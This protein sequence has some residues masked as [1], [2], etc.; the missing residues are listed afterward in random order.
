MC[1]C[2]VDFIVVVRHRVDASNEGV[3]LRF[4]KHIRTSP[5]GLHMKIPWPVERVYE[6]SVQRIKTLEFGFETEHAGRVT[7]YIP[8]G[9]EHLDVAE[10]LTGDLN[11]AHVE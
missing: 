5:P 1:V 2:A 8:T 7:E 6:V 3:V 10:M 9:A 4:G 11:L